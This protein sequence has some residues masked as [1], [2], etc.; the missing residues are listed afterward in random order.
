MMGKSGSIVLYYNTGGSVLVLYWCFTKY[1]QY[2]RLCN[3]KQY[4]DICMQYQRQLD[5][6]PRNFNAI[7]K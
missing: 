2:W 1:V 7:T 3:T 5:E 6:I 4:Q